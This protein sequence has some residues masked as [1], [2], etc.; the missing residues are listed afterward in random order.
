MDNDSND[1][2]E[3]PKAKLDKAFRELYDS[4]DI[5]GLVMEYVKQASEP[6]LKIA[7]DP[8]DRESLGEATDQIHNI[9]WNTG[10]D[11]FIAGMKLGQNVAIKTW[12]QTIDKMA[13]PKD[14]E[15]G[16]VG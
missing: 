2:N 6:I 8:Y 9:I 4:V 10:K 5:K 7:R 11:A 16:N 1:N 12:E 3:D 14:K 15:Q 13:S